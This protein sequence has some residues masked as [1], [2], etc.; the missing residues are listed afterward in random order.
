[1]SG[2]LKSTVRQRPVF[3][4]MQ[5]WAVMGAAAALVAL[6]FGLNRG[7]DWRVVE[8]RGTGSAMVDGRQVALQGADLARAIRRGAHVTLAEGADLDLVAPGM[9][10]VNIAGGSDVVLPAAPN[11]WW[12]RAAS[13][14]VN[15]GSAY[16]TT[17]SGFH[18]ATLAMATPEAVAHV[19]GTSLAVLRDREAGTCVC[20]MRG[21]VVVSY[22]EE[23]EGKPG[24][25]HQEALT[26][27]AGKRCICPIGGEAEIGP[28]LSSSEHAL[29]AQSARS[30]AALGQ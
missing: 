23:E 20:V 16:I 10:A 11:R 1:V 18:G 29:H 6:A 4:R 5:W 24:E 7:P 25:D 30:A 17:G 3:A 15:V 13:G 21:Q 12:S 2:S 19:T 9:L 27:P 8:V 14:R 26:V 22:E 28:I